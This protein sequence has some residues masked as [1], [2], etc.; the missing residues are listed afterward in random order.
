MSTIFPTEWIRE[1]RDL[2]THDVIN[3]ETIIIRRISWLNAMISAHL[4]TIEAI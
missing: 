4:F 2:K 1:W 3:M